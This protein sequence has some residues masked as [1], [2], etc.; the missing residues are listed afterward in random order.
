MNRYE[1]AG[2]VTEAPIHPAAQAKVLLPGTCHTL[3]MSFDASNSSAHL[4]SLHLVFLAA[5]QSLLQ[6]SIALPF[7]S[8][9]I[10]GFSAILFES[11]VTLVVIRQLHAPLIK[12][13]QSR[14]QVA[15]AFKAY[16]RHTGSEETLSSSLS[17][18]G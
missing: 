11:H 1:K 17:R 10:P 5:P 8:F 3:G 12:C 7:E 18:R 4:P 9:Y 15:S 14:H 2:K 6:I 16:T 13:T